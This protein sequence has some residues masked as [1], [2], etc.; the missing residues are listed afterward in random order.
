M[1]DLSFPLFAVMWNQTQR[2]VTP[3]LHIRIA[4][5]LEERGEAQR[6]L[7]A[8]RGGGK[9]TLVG[10]YCAWHLRLD[11]N[12]RILVLSADDALAAR[13]VRQVKRILER[14]PATGDLRP[15]FAD[16]WASD[17]FTV[18]RPMELRDPSMLAK[19]VGAN[20]TGCRAD[21]IVCDDVEV[22]NTCDTPEKRNDLRE[23]LTELSYI[24]TPGGEILYV[25]T[26]HHADS[27][28]NKDH[29]RLTGQAPFLHGTPR[30]EIPVIDENGD[31][32]WPE[33]FT[34]PEIERI[35]RSTGPMKFAS[36][37]MLQPVLLQDCRLDPDALIVEDDPAHHLVTQKVAAWDPAF[38]TRGGDGSVLAV[39]SATRDGRFHI[40]DVAW[41]KID[42]HSEIDAASQQCRA[43]VSLIQAHGVS[44][45]ILETNGIGKFLPAL[46]RRE[47]KAARVSCA[48]IETT[49]RT[50]KAERILAAFDP[51]LAARS[52]VMHPR[53]AKSPL[54]GELRAFHP[55]GRGHDDGLDACAAAILSLSVSLPPLPRRTS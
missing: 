26:P 14:H 15:R 25:G 39:V 19:G 21:L 20:L 13:M 47:L 1:S 23:R 54:I 53:V 38:G 37:M 22:P 32:A 29:D 3:R 31:S 49:S 50:N 18:K 16:Q 40:N 48:V 44:R 24:L 2:Q 28:Y 35:R 8:F 17:R 5:W 6:L 12:I 36:Q 27:L 33:R 11:P 9:S 55:G 45:L 7:M 46:L 30:L 4:R 34:L 51:L 52:L 43:V 41:L 42:E 10:L